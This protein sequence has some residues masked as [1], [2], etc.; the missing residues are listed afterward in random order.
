M[1]GRQLLLLVALGAGAAF[2]ACLN[3]QPLPP[4]EGSAFGEGAES[5]ASAP[6]GGRLGAENPPLGTQDAAASDHEGGAHD[7]DAGGDSGDAGDGD[8]ATGG[9]AAT[10]GG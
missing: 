3:P 7:G 2:V 4:G 9:D 1:G 6:E 10:D 8:A 5:D